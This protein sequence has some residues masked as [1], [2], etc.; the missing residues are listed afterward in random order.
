MKKIKIL[1]ILAGLLSFLTMATVASAH[2]VTIGWHD[3]LDGTV[4]LWG[5]HWHG[6]QVSP[7]TANGGL[8]VTDLATST[9]FVTQWIGLQNNTT[10]ASMLGDGT[11]TGADGGT[12]HAGSG[13]EHDWFYT[14]PLVIGNGS[15][16]FFTGTACCIDTMSSPVQVTLT[17][18][19]SV[20]PG[21]GPGGAGD[22][23][24]EPATLL[25]FGGGLA[26]LIGTQIRRR[27]KLQA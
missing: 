20:P 10:L 8:T 17:G 23:V 21:T 9:S 2:L 3:N 11:L 12:G 26:G 13:M 1:G 27:R 7:S 15:W 14:N 18:I 16:Q 4:T 22:P 25:L 6:D 19:T 5:E 24:P